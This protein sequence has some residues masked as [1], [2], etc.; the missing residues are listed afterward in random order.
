MYKPYKIILNNRQI[1]IKYANNYKTNDG[2][3]LDQ[4]PDVTS[5]PH[6]SE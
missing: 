2:K 1:S 6:L 4:M 3:N 5:K